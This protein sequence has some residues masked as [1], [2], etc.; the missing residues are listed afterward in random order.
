MYHTAQWYNWRMTKIAAILWDMD[1]VLAD[2]KSLHYET[3]KLLLDTQGIPFDAEQ[4]D[5]VFG[6][7]NHS[8]LEM[9]LGRPPSP[10]LLQIVDQVKEETFRRML[11]GRVRLLPGVLSWLEDIQ[12]RNLP[13]VVASSAPA[14]NI[15]AVLDSLGIA[16][17]FT[18]WVSGHAMP[19]K[20][21]PDV[22]LEAARRAGCPP[23]VCLVIE[24]A[25]AGITAARRAGMTCLAV[26]NTHAP[27]LLGEA[28][29]VLPSLEGVSVDSILA[30][31]R[32]V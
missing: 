25:P 31:V 4:F 2:T 6:R 9:L 12:E 24:D 27:D 30:Q 17:F 29:I 22:F 10:S 8:T 32:D 26:A 13:Q 19:G 1:G 16:G 21:E 28:T 5:R 7:N 18:G 23:A 3:W 20:P 11:P 14:E 15:T